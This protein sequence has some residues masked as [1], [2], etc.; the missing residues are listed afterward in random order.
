MATSPITG[1][2]LPNTTSTDQV[3]ADL[4]TAFTAAEKLWIGSFATASA[5]DTKIPSPVGGM[6]A[7]LVSPGKF[8][9]YDAI[10]AGWLDMFNPTAWTAWTPTLQSTGGT[11]FNLG[12]GATQK[13]RYQV[14]GKTVNFQCEWLFGTSVVGPGGQLVFALPPGLPGA[15]VLQQTGS[16]ALY[17]PSGSANYMGFWTVFASGTTAQPHFPVSNTNPS[18]QFFQDTSDGSSAG[19]GIPLVTGTAVNFPIQPSGA[20]VASGTYQTA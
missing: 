4:L 16:C 11:A 3:P 7:W 9:Y 10:A 15:S 6:V 20:L 2:P 13:G 5:R 8:V 18:M 1:V 19:T 12:S 14:I 17:V